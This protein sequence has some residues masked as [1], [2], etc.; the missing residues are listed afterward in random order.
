MR[1][2][3]Q[4]ALSAATCA[5]RAMDSAN[6]GLI[7]SSATPPAPA[8]PVYCETH[9]TPPARKMSPSLAL[10]AWKAIRMVWV[11][12]AQNRLT[13]EPG[14]R[15]RPASTAMIRAMLEPCLPL[16]SAQPQ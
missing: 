11:E 14:S 9:S 7:A 3:L 12:E 6:L 10:I 4:V 1:G 5:V 16:G 2:S 8:K 15:S 13:V